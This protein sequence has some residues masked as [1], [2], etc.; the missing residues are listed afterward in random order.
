MGHVSSRTLRPARPAPAHCG[1]HHGLFLRVHSRRGGGTSAARRAI[2][3][4]GSST[5]CVVPSRYGVFSAQRTW[6]EAVSATRSVA[7]GGRLM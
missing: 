5:I 7:T 6:P 1:Q 4:S 2:K 3:S